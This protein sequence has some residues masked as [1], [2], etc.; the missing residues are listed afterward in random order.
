M[1]YAAGSLTLAQGV[2]TLEVSR[3]LGHAS[4]DITCLLY[5]HVVPQT[6][7]QALDAVERIL[8]G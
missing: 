5:A 3:V 1:P 6:Q 2:P 7:L 8:S 4:V